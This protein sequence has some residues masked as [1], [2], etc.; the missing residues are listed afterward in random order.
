MLLVVYK[1]PKKKEV[2]HTLESVLKSSGKW[3]NYLNNCY[4][5]KTEES[6]DDW[7]DKIRSIVSQELMFIVVDITSQKHNGW[8]PVDAWDWL[9]NK[10]E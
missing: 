6:V 1:E 10:E 7:V 8:L 4:I 5:I 9:K 3:W 2:L